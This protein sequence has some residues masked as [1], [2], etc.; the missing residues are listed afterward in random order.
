MKS[1]HALTRPWK[2][3]PERGGRNVWS[4]HRQLPWLPSHG[5]QPVGARSVL[6]HYFGRAPSTISNLLEQCSC[7]NPWAQFSKLEQQAANFEQQVVFPLTA[8]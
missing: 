3:S 1:P 5:S 6:R 2:V 8:D 4:G 7:E